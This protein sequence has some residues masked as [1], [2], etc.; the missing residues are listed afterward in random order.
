MSMTT[1]PF[2][3]PDVRE[4]IARG[5]ILRIA[6][7]GDTAAIGQ[8]GLSLRDGVGRVVGALA[9]HVGL[10]QPKQAVYVR[11]GEQHD[12]IDVFERRDHL[13]AIG[14]AQ[15]RPAG[16][17]QRLYGIIVVDG[18]DQRVGLGRGTR[19]IPHMTHVQDVETSVGKSNRASLSP[20]GEN[21][22]LEI[23]LVQNPSH[24]VFIPSSP[25]VFRLRRWVCIASR[26]SSGDTVAVPRFI[27]TR[28]PA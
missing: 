19:E 14:A 11:I 10:Q 18:D 13:C 8:H 21:G 7:D 16:S 22:L 25:F 27:T 1:G 17:L 4:Q 5:M 3:N 6:D 26:N 28:P 24:Q 15:D 12:V 23:A 20:F 9:M 2:K